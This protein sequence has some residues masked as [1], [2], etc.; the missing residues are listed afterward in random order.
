M[1][2]RL[3]PD[4]DP[5]EINQW[6]A[7]SESGGTHLVG[8]AVLVADRGDGRLAGFVEIGSRTYAEGCISSPVAFLEGWYVDPDARRRGLGRQLVDAAE[9]WA[10]ERGYLEIASDTELENEI[11]LKA[12]TALGYEEV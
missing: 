7:A 2:S 8:I 9:S 4:V 12:H 10:L 6:F 11:S 5:D 1:R 3:Y